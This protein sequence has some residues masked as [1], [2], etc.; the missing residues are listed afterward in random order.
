MKYIK[1]LESFFDLKYE[2]GDYIKFNDKT[3]ISY[4]FAKIIDSNKVLISYKCEY[5]FGDEI[6]VDWIQES[7]IQ[8]LM[9]PEEKENFEIK[10]NRMKYNL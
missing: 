4:P 6:D 7:Y 3:N 8:R 1:T 5:F 2:I 9:T 10:I